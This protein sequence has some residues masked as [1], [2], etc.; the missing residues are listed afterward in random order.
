M[1]GALVNGKAGVGAQ[2]TS[3]DE[4]G[5]KGFICRIGEAQAKGEHAQECTQVE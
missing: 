2:V 1:S 4:T 5:S 3:A